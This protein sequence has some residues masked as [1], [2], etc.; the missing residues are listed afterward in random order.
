ME[1]AADRVGVA[2]R[3]ISI[4]SANF[5]SLFYAFLPLFLADSVQ[6]NLVF[7]DLYW[8]SKVYLKLADGH[9]NLTK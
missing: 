3:Y 7:S 1:R 9:S 2:E 5:T 4:K 6:F 8:M